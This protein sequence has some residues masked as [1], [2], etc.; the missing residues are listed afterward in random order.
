[1]KVIQSNIKQRKSFWVIRENGEHFEYK[2]GKISKR[3]N[4]VN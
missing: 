3:L 1:M 2:R 4:G